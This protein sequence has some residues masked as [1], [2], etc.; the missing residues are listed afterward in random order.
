MKEIQ[1]YIHHIKTASVVECLRQAGYKNITL[2]DVKGTLKSLSESE[3][4]YSTEAELMISEVRLS[5]VCEDQQVPEIAKLIRKEGYIGE[6]VSG[7]IY[8]SHIEKA[9]PIDGINF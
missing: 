4:V 5:L 6:G 3:K 1:A 8:I 2:L 7:W 9:L